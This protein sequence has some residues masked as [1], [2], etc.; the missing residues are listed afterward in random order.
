MAQENGLSSLLFKDDE[1]IKQ[2][3]GDVLK[4]IKNKRASE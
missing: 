1:E 3:L 2:Y 4:E